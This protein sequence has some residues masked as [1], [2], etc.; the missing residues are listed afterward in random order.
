MQI[1]KIATI[2]PVELLIVPET[3]DGRN[4]TNR[5]SSKHAQVAANNDL[6]AIRAWLQNYADTKTTFD[7]YRKEAERL[8]LW[9]VIELGK[10]LSSITHEDLLEFQAFLKNPQPESRWVYATGRKYPRGDERWRPFSGP[11]S[12]AS[13]RQAKVILNGMFT[14]L[15]SAGYLRGNPMALSRNRS[16]APSTRMTRYL[17][18]SLWD[19]VKAFVAQLPQESDGQKAYYA[20]SRWLTTLFYLQGMRISEVA[21][22][23]MGQ[24]FKRT[25]ADGRAKWWLETLGKGDKERIL[26]VSTELIEELRRYRTAN[27]LR[28][29]PVRSEETPLVI[30]VKGATR[31]LSRVAVHNAMKSIFTGAAMWLR[32]RGTEFADLADDLDHASA[33]WLRHT[34]AS[35]MADS[36]M[37]LHSVRDNLGH[38]S[39]T[40][41]SLYVHS[42]DDKRHTETVERHR[43]SWED[44]TESNPDPE[45]I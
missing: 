35:H 45:E 4:G 15:V 16:K 36:G 23:M 2:Q 27:G 25:A 9:T 10:P 7:S 30:P 40:T 3:L 44:A 42:E 13:Q 31:C 41:T 11:L 39:L 33:H 38:S 12:P 1:A 21:G 22:G 32:S 20:R 24:F 17:S 18:A 29:L 34:A 26:P 14:W 19:E 8:L 28:P 37:D 6:D 43:M 5:G